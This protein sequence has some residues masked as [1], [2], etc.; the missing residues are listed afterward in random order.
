MEA[1]FSSEQATVPA[2]RV[3][4]DEAMTVDDIDVYRSSKLLIDKHGDEAPIHDVVPPV[5]RRVKAARCA[6]F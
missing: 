2:W 1:A 4:G 3:E 6:P 5:D